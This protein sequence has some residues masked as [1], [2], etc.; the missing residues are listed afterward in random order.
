M[1]KDDDDVQNTKQS[2]QDLNQGN[3]IIENSNA[4]KKVPAGKTSTRS[5]TSRVPKSNEKNGKLNQP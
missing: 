1:Q 3:L 2:F 5:K 4:T